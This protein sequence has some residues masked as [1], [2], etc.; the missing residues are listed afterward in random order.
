MKKP[1]LL[2]ILTG[3]MLP[4]TV[5]AE[6]VSK[7]DEQ[8]NSRERLNNS[9]PNPNYSADDIE[10]EIVFGRELASKITGKFPPIKNDKLNS[11][12]NKVGQ[13]VAQ[14]SDRSE[15]N[16][17]FLLIKS[18]EINAFASPGGYVFITTAALDQV[19]DEAELAGILAHEIA[20]IEKRHYVKKA[21]I[22]SNKSSP[23]QGF[24][25][26]L[27][28]GKVSSVLAF[29][30]AIDEVAEILFSKGLQSHA[31]EFEADATGMWL[32]ANT[33]YDPKALGRYLKRIAKLKKQTKTLAATH[34]ALKTRYT[35][36]NQLLKKNQLNNLQQAKL[37][38][39]YHEHK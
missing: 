8:K 25:T 29:Q 1:T 9:F 34:P 3:L 16:Y 7:I 5:P 28:G 27:T 35:K 21:G 12:I 18:S 37:E 10:A 24:N 6:Q 31:D 33:G 15:L 2:F 22:R 19:K 38:E 11:Y 26:M 14:S 17:R 39:R 20:H 32:L 13:L 4:H 30:A 23:E 36:L